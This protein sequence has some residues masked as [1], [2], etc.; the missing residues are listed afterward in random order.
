MGTWTECVYHIG[1][2]PQERGQ[3]GCRREEGE[4]L[5]C[6]FGGAGSTLQAVP[7]LCSAVTI[8]RGAMPLLTPRQPREREFVSRTDAANHRRKALLLTPPGALCCAERTCSLESWPH[9]SGP[10]WLCGCKHTAPTPG[11]G[12]P[13][14]GATPVPAPRGHPEPPPPV[15]VLPPST[16]DWAALSCMLLVVGSSPPAEAAHSVLK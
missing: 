9:T 1:H 8:P 15:S 2:A 12:G 3:W 6:P 13:C 14:D 7:W 4:G 10:T 11:T 5:G 16:P